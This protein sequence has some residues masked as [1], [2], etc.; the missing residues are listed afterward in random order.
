MIVAVMDSNIVDVYREIR[1]SIIAFICSYTEEDE[2]PM[3]PEIIGTGFVVSEDGIIVTN[4]HILENRNKEDLLALSFRSTPESEDVYNLPLGIIDF[5]IPAFHSDN[6]SFVSGNIA[7][8][9]VDISGLPALQIDEST[10][11]EEGLE[12]GLSGYLTG[13]KGLSAT[14]INQVIPSLQKGIISCV[15]PYPCSN[16][17]SFSIDIMTHAGAFGSPIF[18]VKDGKILGMLCASETL[19]EKTAKKK[20]SYPVPVPISFASPVHYL[21]QGL[22]EAKKKFDYSYDLESVDLSFDEIDLNII[23]DIVSF[24]IHIEDEPKK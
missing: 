21:M 16:P 14:T 17:Y 10:L 5:H 1:K 22:E 11:I 8:V 23:D 2:A 15:Q 12:V 3:F 20:V 18:S 6:P 9:K 19:Q 7:F 13:N 24:R 4:S